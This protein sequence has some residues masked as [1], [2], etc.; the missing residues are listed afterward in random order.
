MGLALLFSVERI[1]IIIIVMMIMTKMKT[2][3]PKETQTVEDDCYRYCVTFPKLCTI[4]DP[5]HY[6]GMRFWFQLSLFKMISSCMRAF[7][8]FE[9]NRW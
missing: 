8:Q 1:I 3:L 2:V 6:F 4:G 5:P 9:E 7:A